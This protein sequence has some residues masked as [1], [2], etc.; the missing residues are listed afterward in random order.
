MGVHST[1]HACKQSICT[2]HVTHVRTNQQVHL[3][4][5]R[6]ATG[7]LNESCALL[8]CTVFFIVL[9]LQPVAGEFKKLTAAWQAAV[10]LA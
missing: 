7:C 10:F 6:I 2:S 3:Y 5:S 4:V 1:R 8:R 9:A